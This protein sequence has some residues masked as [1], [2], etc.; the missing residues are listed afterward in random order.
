MTGGGSEKRRG[1]DAA[2]RAET[3]R[4]GEEALD[5][6]EGRGAEAVG[7]A[8]AGRGGEKGHGVKQ[9]HGVEQGHDSPRPAH[10]VDG[11]GLGRRPEDEVED[12]IA[13][14]L[15]AR[16]DELVESGL[17]R[18]QA[19][20]QAETEF[21]DADDARRALVATTTRRRQKSRRTRVLADVAQDARVALRGIRTRPGWFAVAALSLA[22]GIGAVSTMWTALDRLM[23]RPLPYDPAGE[24]VFV[25]TRSAGVGSASTPQAPADFL[26]LRAS[27]RTIALAAYQGGGVNVGGDPPQWMST[28]AVT[29]NFFDVAG[30]RPAYGRGFSPEDTEVGS[31]AVTILDHDVWTAGYGADPGV[32]GTNIQLNGVPTTVVGVMP[33]GFSFGFDS[34]DLWLPLRIEDPAAR[35]GWSLNVVGRRHQNIATV[36]QELDLLA[37]GLAERYPATNAERTFPV[38][39]LVDVMFGGPSFDQGM[40]GSMIAALMV[41]LIACANVANMLLARGSERATEIALRRAIGASRGRVLRQLLTEAVILAF[42]G[43]ALGAAA[44]IAGI[45]GLRHLVPAGMPRS[46]ELFVDGRTL[47]A[48]MLAALLSVLLFGLIPALRTI[49]HGDRGLAHGGRSASARR[50]GR[51]RTLL[52]ATE[53]ALSVVLVTISGAVLASIRAI[54]DVDTGFVTE[55]VWTFSFTLPEDRF[56]ALEEAAPA[57]DVVVAGLEALPELSRVGLGVGLPGQGWISLPAYLPEEPTENPPRVVTRLADPGYLEVLGLEPTRGRALTASD[58]GNAPAVILI[59]ESFAGRLWPERDPVGQMLHLDSRAVEVVGVLP[60]VREWG[61]RFAPR[62]M[63]Y[64]PLAQWPRRTISVVARSAGPAPPTSAIHDVVGRLDGNVAVRNLQ[65]FDSVLLQSAEMFESMFRLMAVM[66]T[67]ALLLAVVGVYASMSFTVARRSPEI[68][69]RMALGADRRTVR[70][71]IAR[72][73]LTV[74]AAGLAAGLPL[75]WAASQGMSVFLFGSAG[76]SP[77]AYAAVAA[78]I[79]TVSVAAAWVPARRASAVDPMTVLR[80][81]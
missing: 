4:G 10:E 34:P 32:V 49:A 67:A 24:L 13:F 18:D 26:D 39:G 2:G 11:V 9:G 81:E 56:P 55:N 40:T 21:G 41:L 48:G 60:N 79:L 25:G 33:E 46:D 63:V 69:V 3:G 7:R 23:L 35:A 68:G 36:R 29:A 30:V 65:T 72:G 8:E 61:P 6:A 57:L 54:E 64:A 17:D 14:H 45:R 58:D 31:P 52:V 77:Q 71:M 15:A 20:L 73:A 78:L 51:G 53:I 12:E 62:S 16:V 1:S 19:L 50:S 59:N 76:S 43:G 5:A 22:V 42:V 44:S 70:T 27:A 80:G 74:A 38:A 37:A 66:A 28:R 75:A 47:A